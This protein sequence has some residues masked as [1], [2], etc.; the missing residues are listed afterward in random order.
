MAQGPQKAGYGSVCR[1]DEAD[2][3]YDFSYQPLKQITMNITEKQSK[4]YWA[5]QNVLDY[6]TGI[7]YRIIQSKKLI[8][9]VSVNQI[10]SISGWREQDYHQNMIMP[11]V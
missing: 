6:F 9:Y 1:Q 11:T 4:A 3:N 5:D 8:G 7:I 10:Q 2:F